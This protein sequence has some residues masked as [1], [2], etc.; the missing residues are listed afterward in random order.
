[1][2]HIEIREEPLAAIGDYARIPSAFRVERVLRVHAHP[3]AQSQW[4]L[5]EEPCAAPFVKDYDA[6]PGNHAIDWPTQFDSAHWQVFVAYVRDIRVGGAILIPPVG[7]SPSVADDQVSELWDLRV[8]PDWQRRGI[9]TALWK[10]VESRVTTPLLRVETQQ[11]NVAA[12][13]FYSTQGCVLTRVE[14]FAYPEL[15]NEIR[16]V[17]QKVTPRSGR[18]R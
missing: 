6:I 17:W 11:I 12:C 1:M 3:T 10:H 8:H 4:S 7:A 14:P 15:P 2:I 18:S 16:L 9:A 13:A 5:V